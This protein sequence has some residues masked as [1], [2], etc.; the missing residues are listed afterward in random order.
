MHGLSAGFVV[1]CTELLQ[2]SICFTCVF[3]KENSAFLP[4]V[5]VMC[6]ICLEFFTWW[7]RVQYAKELGIGMLLHGVSLVRI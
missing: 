5:F 7:C 1:L 2:G 4:S 6:C 3:R